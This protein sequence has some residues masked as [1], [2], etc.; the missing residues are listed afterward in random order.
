MDKNANDNVVLLR[1][2][3]VASAQSPRR[4]SDR[5]AGLSGLDRS[6]LRTVQPP[7]DLAPPAGFFVDSSLHAQAHA[8]AIFEIWS[9]HFAHDLSSPSMSA[10]GEAAWP[11]SDGFTYKVP[12]T[13]KALARLAVVWDISSD[14]LAVLLG[15]G[16]PADWTAV[17][18]GRKRFERDPDRMERIKLLFQLDSLIRSMYRDEGTTKRWLRAEIGSFGTSALT[19][20]LRGPMRHLY[21]VVAWVQSIP[22]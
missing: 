17:L 5:G 1:E 15:Y 9:A 3:Q 4:R 8:K 6:D 16:R 14:E 18:E 11:R 22:K 20:M 13:A 7:Y 12:A 21:E 2:R 10:P 19:W